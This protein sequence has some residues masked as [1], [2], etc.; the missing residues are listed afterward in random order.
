V[1]KINKERGDREGTRRAGEHGYRRRFDRMQTS[2]K[3]D[4]MGPPLS[5][6]L[7]AKVT[8]L[9]IKTTRLQRLLSKVDPEKIA[10]TNEVVHAKRP[11]KTKPGVITMLIL[12]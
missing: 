3:P 2:I 11:T 5:Q 1:E 12:S 6:K 8:Q 9:P 10:R 7:A 4:S